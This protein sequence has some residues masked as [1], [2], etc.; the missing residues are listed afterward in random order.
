MCES[1]WIVRLTLG[2]LVCATTGQ[3]QSPAVSLSGT[4][5]LVIGAGE[6]RPEYQMDRVY[7]ATRLDD[8][9]IVVGHSA[10]SQ[11]RY[12]DAKGRYLASS[13]RSGAGPGEFEP[14]YTLFPMRFG[15][16][17]LVDDE[18]H[19]RI[20][21]YTARGALRPQLQLVSTPA[22]TQS[23]LTAVTTTRLVARVTSN[24]FFRGNPGDRI[25]TKYRYAVYDSTGTQQALLFELPTAE[26][27]VHA[28][29]GSIRY[30]FLPFSPEPR[31]AAA[32]DR[33]YLIRRGEPEVEIWSSD[34]KLIG[35]RRWKA[36]RGKVRDIWARWRQQFLDG[37]TRQRDKLFYTDFLSDKLPLPE[38]VPVAEALHADP[39]GRLWVV[40]TK[41]PWETQRRADVL[42]AN[43]RLAGTVTLP[44]RFTVLDVGR[45]YLLGRTLD[46][47]D[48]ERVEL[49]R[50]SWR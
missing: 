50:V 37:I 4:P 21:R 45:D 8:G 13:G 7:G 43:G 10:S 11:L 29:G 12:F 27:I 2:A 30:P 6:T 16:S 25:A 3:A 24:P 14:R 46:E 40:R 20:N 26:R 1:R 9:T 35:T 28:Y 33:I 22:A 38:F 49:Y 39:L 19:A 48:V 15:A 32:G 17:I 41:L 23:I 42:D 31:V 18:P 36:E 5:V 34:A 44:P 47:D